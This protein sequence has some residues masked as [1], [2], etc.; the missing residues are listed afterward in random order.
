MSRACGTYA[1][2]PGFFLWRIVTDGDYFEALGIDVRTIL[3]RNLRKL[4][5]KAWDG[6][7]WPRIGT[8]VGL[9]LKQ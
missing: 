8:F 3:K 2:I 7:I 9:L 6:L 1:S 5:G 4:F